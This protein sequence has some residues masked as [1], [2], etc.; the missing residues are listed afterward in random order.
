MPDTLL[1]GKVV[2]VTGAARGIGAAEARLFAGSGAVVVAADIGAKVDELAPD[3][4]PAGFTL[5]LDVTDE[6]AWADAIGAVR[7]QCGRLDGL[8]NN[9]GI[10]G[11]AAPIGE[12]AVADYRRVVEVNQVGTF[13]GMRHAAGLMRAGGG[14]SIVNVS[15][16]AG[17]VGQPHTVAYS[18]SKWAVRGMT[19]VAAIELGPDG[20]RV[21]T[22]LP[23]GI[24]T[25][26]LSGRDVDAADAF[27]WERIP[28]GRVGDP[29]EVARVARFLLSDESSY[30]TG[31]EF[32]V[33]GGYSTGGIDINR[34]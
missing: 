17:L 24:D 28:S 9:A 27:A 8:V 25:R 2:L 13:L 30:C 34:E 15:S 32:V 10:G 4:G 26:L 16:V 33:D 31:A 7:E 3:L 1:T 22:I 5:Q 11:P 12:T 29:R 23:G 21:N 18:A 6:D 14:G 20:I 19:K